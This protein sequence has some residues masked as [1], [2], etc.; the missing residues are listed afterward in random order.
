VIQELK[1]SR[2]YEGEIVVAIEERKPFYPAEEE[3]QNYAQKNKVYYALY[4]N[5][6]GRE[7]F[8]NKTCAIREEKKIVWKH[9]K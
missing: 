2:M 4:R 8:V 9:L 3:H 7:N 5:G 1:E 6:S